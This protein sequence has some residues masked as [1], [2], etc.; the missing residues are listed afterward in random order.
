MLL[1][2]LPSVSEQYLWQHTPLAH[3]HWTMTAI[4]ASCCIEHLASHGKLLS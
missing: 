4:P 2:A 1:G 3:A